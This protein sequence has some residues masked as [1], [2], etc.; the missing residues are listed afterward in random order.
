QRGGSAMKKTW[1]ILCAVA[2]LTTVAV[3]IMVGDDKP[4]ETPVPAER[5]EDAQAV[6]AAVEKFAE[7][8]QKGDAAAAAAMPASGAQLAPDE[9]EP[10]RGRDAIQ[11]ALTE[12]FAKTPRAKFE[13]EFEPV[14]FTSRDAAIQEG[15]MKITAAKG[16]SASKKFSIL[17]LR[18]DGKWLLGYIKEW[19]DEQEDLKDLDWLIGTWSAKSGDQEVTTTYEWF[20]NKAFI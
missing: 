10:L 2:A 14:R 3:G 17:S 16:E 18:E 4:K 8:F 11:K 6:R 19:P 13:L 1:M 20:G 9:G 7:A 15:T 5:K 12:H